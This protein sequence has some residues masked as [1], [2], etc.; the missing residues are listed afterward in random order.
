MQKINIFQE[1]I[2]LVSKSSVIA[3]ELAG[4]ISNNEPRYSFFRYSHVFEG[5]E[6]API[7]FIYTCPSGSKVKERM[8]YASSR[9][10]V[11]SIAASEGALEVAKRVSHI[12]QSVQ[13]SR[14]HMLKPTLAGIFKSIGSHEH[15]IRGRVSPKTGTEAKLCKTEAAW[16][17]LTTIDFTDPQAVLRNYES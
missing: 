3:E 7:L 9:A 5:Q 1:S 16:K 4:R 13:M 15:C 11:I 6:Q 2:E 12:V 14:I 10:G 8:V 17:A